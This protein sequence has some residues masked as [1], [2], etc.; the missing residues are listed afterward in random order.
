[1]VKTT[2]AYRKVIGSNS[3]KKVYTPFLV[4]SHTFLHAIS[5]LFLPGE[6]SVPSALRLITYTHVHTHTH[7]HIYTHTPLV[8]T[9][10]THTSTHTTLPQPKHTRTR[11]R[12][13]HR[14]LHA[15]LGV[16]IRATSRDYCIKSCTHI[17]LACVQLVHFSWGGYSPNRATHTHPRGSLR[18][19]RGQHFA[20]RGAWS[21][22]Q[23]WERVLQSWSSLLGEEVQA[24][25]RPK[26]LL[27]LSKCPSALQY[28]R[29]CVRGPS[30]SL[31]CVCVR[32][33][34]RSLALKWLGHEGFYPPHTP[35]H[36]GR[37]AN[38]APH[39]AQRRCVWCSM[40]VT[41]THGCA[42]RHILLGG[43]LSLREA[44]LGLTRAW[45]QCP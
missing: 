15:P 16:H 13:L 31:G 2:A 34:L 21:A 11:A 8:Y 36:R 41:C 26:G 10:A 7:T 28:V 23:V 12:G 1:M 45:E 18:L 44:L 27:L 43:L 39:N 32:R 24:E 17:P 14:G 29:V 25:S 3:T 37:R 38:E 33:V 22:L 42:G 35:K 5:P 6:P 40:C 9:L 19:L 20:A 4:A 30:G